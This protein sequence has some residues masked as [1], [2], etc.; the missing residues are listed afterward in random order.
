MKCG[1]G[2]GAFIRAWKVAGDGARF[3][4]PSKRGAPCAFEFGDN[5]MASDV[6]RNDGVNEMLS[7]RDFP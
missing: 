6:S 5:D 3:L 4:G 1:Y 2:F 7:W